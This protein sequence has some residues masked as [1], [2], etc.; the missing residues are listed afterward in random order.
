MFLPIDPSF[1]VSNVSQSFS[2][3]VTR[4]EAKFSGFGFS[5]TWF[6]KPTVVGGKILGFFLGFFITWVA[7]IQNV[8][9]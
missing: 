7:F 9:V 5:L 3:C 1:R 6:Q 4:R 8:S 2:Y